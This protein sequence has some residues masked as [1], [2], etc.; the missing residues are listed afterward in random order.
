MQRRNAFTLIE[1]LVVIAIIAIL[2]AILFP[3]FAQAKAAAKKAT[4]VSNLKQLGTSIVLYANDADDTMPL[5]VGFRD[6]WNANWC[7]SWALTTQPYVKTYDVYRSPMDGKRTAPADWQ[8]VG[9]SFAPNA[10]WNGNWEPAGAFGLWENGNTFWQQPSPTL[11]SIGRVA[12][13]IALAERHNDTMAGVG[14]GNN[15]VYSTPFFGHNWIEFMGKGALTPDGK[16]DPAAKFPEG[17]D[18]AVTAKHAGQAT[19]LFCDSHA[20][21]MKPVQTNPDFW[22]DK[23]KNMWDRRRN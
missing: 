2:A 3:V 20:K 9:I 23:E 10:A 14:S 11:T 17:R 8:G 6:E 19:F 5:A 1:L 7:S 15:T 22:G 16:R 12:E 4:T 13:T 18:G 21:S